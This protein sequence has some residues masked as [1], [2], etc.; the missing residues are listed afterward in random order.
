[1][2]QILKPSLAQPDWQGLMMCST[3]SSSHLC[4]RSLMQGST[5]ARSHFFSHFLM[6]RQPPLHA[7]YLAPLHMLLSYPLHCAVHVSSFVAPLQ[8]RPQGSTASAAT[9]KAN[10]AATLATMVCKCLREA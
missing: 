2:A 10:N 3:H 8:A 4:T 1:M 6:K 5:I 7:M 9:T